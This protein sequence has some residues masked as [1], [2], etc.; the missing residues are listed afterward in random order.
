MC[1]LNEQKDS[2]IIAKCRSEG[3]TGL[4]ANPGGGREPSEWLRAWSSHAT[5]RSLSNGSKAREPLSASAV[6]QTQ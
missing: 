1:Y 5:A 6:T 2:K 3:K 4:E